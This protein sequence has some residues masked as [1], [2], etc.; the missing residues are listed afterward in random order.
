MVG[1]VVSRFNDLITERLLDGAARV[2]E[3]NGIEFDVHW[4]EGSFEIP[5]LIGKL[6]DESDREYEGFIALGCIIKGETDHNDHI[7]RAVSYGLMKLAIE[8]GIPITFGI[9]TVDSIEQALN[10]AGGKFGNK[11]EEAARAL[12]PLIR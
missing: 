9:L 2:L 4:V 6:I 8:T 12:L 3:E 11:G 7:A 5:Q 1:I 10:R